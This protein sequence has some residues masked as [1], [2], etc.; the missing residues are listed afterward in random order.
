LGEVETVRHAIGRCVSRIQSRQTEDGLTKF[1]EADVGVQSFR[2]IPGSGIGTQDQTADPTAIAE[3]CTVRPFFHFRR[4]DMI[5]PAAPIIPSD[6]DRSLRP[7]TAFNYGVHL[8]DGP[9]H[10]VG[11]ISDWRI[12]TLI[13]R[14]GRML[15]ERVRRVDPGNGGK[16]SRGGVCGELSG[17]K[18]GPCRQSFNESERVATI[19]GPCKAGGV[20]AGRQGRKVIDGISR[21]IVYDWRLRGEKHQVI[22]SGRTSNVS[23]IVIT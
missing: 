18:L 11:D 14:V 5:I 13:P 12:R 20:K 10:A 22:R 3:L 23:E 15:T 4:I 6:E 17:G 2:D 7:Q 19:V 9:L 8:G 1:D 21:G 16:S